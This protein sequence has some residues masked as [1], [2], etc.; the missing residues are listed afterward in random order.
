MKN[1]SQIW[2]DRYKKRS[3]VNRYPHEDVVSFMLRNYR[4][5]KSKVKVLDL[6]CG[7][8]NNLVFLAQ[9]GYDYYGVDYSHSA[10]QII[11]ETFDYFSLNLNKNRLFNS[12]FKK[13]SFEDN[14]FDVVIDRQSIGQNNYNDIQ[15]IINE[16]HRVL[17][18]RG[19]YFGVNFSDRSVEI[20]HGDRIGVN[21]YNNFKKGRFVD[22]GDRHFFNYDEIFTLFSE[23]KVLDIVTRSEA[24]F[25]NRELGAEEIVVI[26]QKLQDSKI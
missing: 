14:F 21:Q 25:Y 20:A 3:V 6:G 2:E 10:L 7:T 8:G 15:V 1:N 17:K 23:F 4:E 11:S 26:S 12:N 13:L 16:I 24:F 5:N 9:E 18:T 19:K 22:L